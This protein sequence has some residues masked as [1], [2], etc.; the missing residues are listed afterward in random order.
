[1]QKLQL[2]LAHILLAHILLAHILHFLYKV[3]SDVLY[4][5]SS[6]CLKLQSSLCKSCSR[7]YAKAAVNSGTYTSGTYTSGTYT[8][9][10]YSSFTS[11]WL[12]HN[13]FWEINPD[14]M[15]MGRLECVGAFGGVKMSE[16]CSNFDEKMKWNMKM[17]PWVF[18]KRGLP[19][20]HEADNWW[21][22]A[23]QYVPYILK[24]FSRAQR[25]C[26]QLY[27]WLFQGITWSTAHV[28]EKCLYA[29]H[30][31]SFKYDVFFE[32]RFGNNLLFGNFKRRGYDFYFR[33]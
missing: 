2:I 14:K 28:E 5:M 33:K 11:P 21:F 23:K 9:H 13:L 10:S 29:F 16:I 8:I 4:V 20:V 32:F 17:L 12:S 31:I 7:H 19:V 22:C 15:Y 24:A 1:M 3:S 30:K 26:Q 18:W 6:L 25:K 27:H